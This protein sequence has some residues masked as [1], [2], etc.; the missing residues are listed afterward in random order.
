[1][2]VLPEINYHKYSGGVNLHEFI[3]VPLLLVLLTFV[4]GLRVAGFQTSGDVSPSSAPVLFVQNVG[5]WD[6]KALFQM[7]GTNGTVWLMEDSIGL[8]FIHIPE[9]EHVLDVD[10]EALEQQEGVY[11]EQNILLQ[12][13]NVSPDVKLVPRN[14]SDTVVSYLLGPNARS[15]HPDVPTWTEVRYE[16]LY[17]GVDLELEST[18]SDVILHFI[19][20]SHCDGS[21]SQ[22]RWRL[23][24]VDRTAIYPINDDHFLG[25]LSFATVNGEFHVFIKQTGFSTGTKYGIFQQGNTG[26]VTPITSSYKGDAVRPPVVQENTSSW[27]STFIGTSR[28]EYG[29]T[30]TTSRTGGI[31][32]G[33][34]TFSS[35]FPTSWGVV[36]RSFA[37][38]REG[39]I[40]K[41]DASG[42]G[43]EFATFL[44]GSNDD[45]VQSVWVD[46]SNYI[47]VGGFTT[48]NNF[49]VTSGAYDTTFNDGV[50]L[51][52]SKLTPQGR[53]FVYSTYIGGNLPE[54]A[55][56]MKVDAS[57]RVYLAGFTYSRD[58]PTTP[59][60]YDRIPGGYITDAFILRLSRYGDRLEFSTLLGGDGADWAQDLVSD[61]SGNIYVVGYTA[62]RDFPTTTNAF[63]R[64]H[65]GGSDAF[66]VKFNTSGSRLLYSTFLGGG[67]EDRG[68]GLAINSGYLYVLGYSKGTVEGVSG[69]YSIHQ[70]GGWDVFLLRFRTLDMQPI[71]G[72]YLGGNEDEK[73]RGHLVVNDDGVYVGGETASRDFP[74]TSG[75][76]DLSYN[77]GTSDNFVAVLSPNLRNL[78]YSTYIGGRGEDRLYSYQLASQRRLCTTGSTTSSNYPVSSNAYDTTF[79][80]DIDAFV[81]CLSLVPSPPPTPTPT[82]TPRVYPDA[83]EPDNTCGNARWLYPGDQQR[84]NFHRSG[85]VDWVQFTLVVGHTYV[86]ETKNLESNA[87]TV[88]ELY[89]PNCSARLASDD[90]SGPGHGSRIEWQPTFSGIYKAKVRP[91][92][93]LNTGRFSG[94]TLTITQRSSWSGR[95]G[96]PL[97]TQSSFLDWTPPTIQR[98]REERDPLY[99]VGCRTGTT[100]WIRADVWDSES[101]L[102]W[103]RVY[104]RAAG[105]VAWRAHPMRHIWGNTYEATLGPFSAPGQI[106]YYVWARDRAGNDRKTPI[107]TLLVEQC[108]V[109]HHS[110]VHVVFAIDT[111]G[112]MEE[113]WA[114]LCSQIGDIVNNLQQQGVMVRHEILG[115]DYPFEASGSRACTGGKTIRNTVPHPTVNHYEDWG[116]GIVDLATQYSW[117]PG[118][119]RV[120]IPISDEGPENGDPV[121]NADKAITD[122]AIDAAQQHKV[123]VSPILGNGTSADVEQIAARI[124]YNTGGT[125]AEFDQ[126]N[127]T[128]IV[129]EAIA[130]AA[131]HCGRYEP[132][133]D[134]RV[135]PWGPL[136]IGVEYEAFLCQGD[137]EDNYFF[138]VDRRQTVQ[139]RVFWPS[140]FVGHGTIWLYSASDLSQHAHICAQAPIMSQQT[141]LSCDLP[142]SGRYII[143]MYADNPNSVYDNDTP[144]SLRVTA[145]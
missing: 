13:L 95:L 115:I 127:M 120:V 23:E 88:I 45:W 32:V 138:E 28:K 97:V 137:L 136:H 44:G 67:S 49:P 66:L 128:Q 98:V 94:Y 11:E 19:C 129:T 111:S 59:G 64:Y 50:D 22:V 139:I 145:P 103:V 121:D 20:T 126:N 132:N 116:P 85:D 92:S 81:T 110:S 63:R 87:D 124:A 15:W 12:F 108:S 51:F 75:A 112:S 26:G 48:S 109:V 62:S 10:V 123:I 6:K 144:Y 131:S 93:A 57:G 118:Y 29:F 69:G 43:M 122:R 106:E 104:Y 71:N 33:G 37:G 17:P 24:G 135:N 70:H 77:G 40:F 25:A 18:G 4:S 9:Q 36:D 74:V 76:F 65:M 52:V 39:F 1:M 3:W 60:A 82:P 73:L 134:R 113:E 79:N 143:R 140:I 21:L 114:S 61:S 35:H 58:F 83:Y 78:L 38:Q 130:N 2:S 56:A 72:T 133:D 42:S 84:H 101:G 46:G 47:Y 119:V 125:V 102:A 30:I 100:S 90:E 41:L 141:L 54:Y 7:W 99:V 5:Q 55:P 8:S 105:Q 53:S 27:Y 31:Y 117:Q 89:A 68:M 107:Y 96:I 14:S 34:F 80:G 86:I 91:F 142:G 16:N